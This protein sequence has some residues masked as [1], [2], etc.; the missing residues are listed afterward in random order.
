VTFD[1]FRAQFLKAGATTL[2][3]STK[4]PGEI[5]DLIAV[6]A[7]VL[8]KQPKAIDALLNGWFAAI[9]YMKADPKDAARRMGIRLQTS[10]EQFL[11][12]QQGLHVPSRAENLKMLGGPTP[13]LAT[14]GRRLMALMIE[15]KLLRGELKIESVLAPQPLEAMAK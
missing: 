14:T 12:A 10:G 4:I 8:A 2:F 3:D 15:S 6:R 13:E 1:P 11:A 9:D 5:V 7:D